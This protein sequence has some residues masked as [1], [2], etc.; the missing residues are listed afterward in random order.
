M[1]SRS[2]DLYVSRCSNYIGTILGRRQPGIPVVHRGQTATVAARAT[3]GTSRRTHAGRIS[4]TRTAA[5]YSVAR[6]HLIRY[7]RKTPT[8][9]ESFLF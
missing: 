6:N 7:G 2:L 5:V 8:L 1:P 3:V 4:R 9:G